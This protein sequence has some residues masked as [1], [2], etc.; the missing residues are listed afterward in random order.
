MADIIRAILP[1]I[2]QMVFSG[3]SAPKVILY[4]ACGGINLVFDMAVFYVAYHYSFWTKF[5][6]PFLHLVRTSF[7]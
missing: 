7:H 1:T 4:M 2:W 3:S 6:T 5:Q